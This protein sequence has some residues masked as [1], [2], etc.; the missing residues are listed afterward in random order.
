MVVAGSPLIHWA[1]CGPFAF[2][3]PFLIYYMMPENCHLS[4]EIRLWS[5][6][7]YKE[8][9]TNRQFNMILILCV[10]SWL[11]FTN[12]PFSQSAIGIKPRK[13]SSFVINAVVIIIIIGLSWVPIGVAARD[14]YSS[15]VPYKN[16][17]SV[18][19]RSP[20]PQAYVKNKLFR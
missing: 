18:Y 15:I 16:V 8:R 7:H 6:L 14:R 4:N 12:S 17:F 11:G 10:C 5:K 13:V 2:S 9:H 3:I 1:L 20:N 19:V